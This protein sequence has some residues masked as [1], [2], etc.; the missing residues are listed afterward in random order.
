MRSRIMA[1]DAVKEVPT[2][3]IEQGSVD[4]VIAREQSDNRATVQ[5]K[6]P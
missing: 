3:G 6:V 1:N 4:Y 2:D 5:G